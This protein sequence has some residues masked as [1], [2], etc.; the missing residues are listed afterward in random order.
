MRREDGTCR[1][2]DDQKHLIRQYS[3]KTPTNFENINKAINNNKNPVLNQIIAQIKH[4]GVDMHQMRKL[5]VRGCEAYYL[6]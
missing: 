2:S 6:T 3:N 4:A 5:R 1:N